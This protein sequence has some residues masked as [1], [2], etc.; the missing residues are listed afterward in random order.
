[1]RMY[2]MHIIAIKAKNKSTRSSSSSSRS[3]GIHHESKR[4]PAIQFIFNSVF[5][6]IYIFQSGI[7]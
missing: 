6:L 2:I 1:M 7:N 3:S 4:E 5:S